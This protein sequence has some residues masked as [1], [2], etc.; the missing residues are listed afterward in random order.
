M[1]DENMREPRQIVTR[2]HAKAEGL[3]HYFTGGSRVSAGIY[4]I[5]MLS[6][7]DVPYA[8]RKVEIIGV[9]ITEIKN[10]NETILDT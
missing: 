2:E 1:A 6:L 7:G 8:T 4:Q 10:E 9:E 3:K 5:D